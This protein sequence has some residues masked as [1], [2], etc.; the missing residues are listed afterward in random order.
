MIP[1]DGS[2]WALYGPIGRLVFHSAGHIPSEVGE[3][4]RDTNTN[5]SRSDKTT[6]NIHKATIPPII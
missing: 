6:E 2:F 3:M 1:A 5:T 4:G